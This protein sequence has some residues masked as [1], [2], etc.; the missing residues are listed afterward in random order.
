VKGE[1][2]LVCW[3]Q[4]SLWTIPARENSWKYWQ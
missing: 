4:N 1:W 2:G 3:N